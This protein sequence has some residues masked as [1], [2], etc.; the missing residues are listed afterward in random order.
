MALVTPRGKLSWGA[1]ALEQ[2]VFAAADLFIG[3]LP[4]LA[5]PT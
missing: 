5:E 2:K 1:L 3:P 4:A